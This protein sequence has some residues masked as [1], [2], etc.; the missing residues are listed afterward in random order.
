[1]LRKIILTLKSFLYKICNMPVE[2]H[3]E[4]R[5]LKLIEFHV[6]FLLNDFMVDITNKNDPK[7]IG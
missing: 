3:I 2:F 1:M 6:S 5:V 7:R 4:R